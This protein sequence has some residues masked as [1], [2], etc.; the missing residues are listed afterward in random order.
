MREPTPSSWRSL[1]GLL[2]LV[3]AVLCL[4]VA[5]HHTPA[6]AL[7]RRTAAWMTGTRSTAR[8]LLAY[9]EGQGAAA[10][11]SNALAPTTPPPRTLTRPEALAAGTH[12][13]LR[14]LQAQERGPVLSLAA[15]LSIPQATLL[16][17]AQGPA[18]TRKLLAA[19]DPEFPEPEARLVALFAGRTPARYA[20]SRRGPHPSL[21]ELA[22]ELPPGLSAASAAAAQALALATAYGLA[23]PLQ[24][25]GPVTSAFGMR[26]HPTLGRRMLHAGVDISLPVGTPVYAAEAGV[27]RRAS[28][29]AVNGKVLIL[30][31]GNGVTTAYLHASELLAGVGDHVARGALIARSGNTGRSTG[32]HLHFQLELNGQPMDPMRFRPRT[33]ALAGPR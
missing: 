19:L 16:D 3:M 28:E 23:W 10:I 20:L 7:L 5:Y 17:E 32:P 1:R 6:G 9:Y 29:D 4:W 13:A 11:L 26:E 18:A 2:D 31:H 22:A 8:P 27:V 30:E 25:S 15:E 14:A 12:L 21:E 24:R 33:T